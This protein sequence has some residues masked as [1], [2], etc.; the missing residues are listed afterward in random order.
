MIPRRAPVRFSW[1]A[2]RRNQGAL[3]RSSVTN[4]SDNPRNAAPYSLSSNCSLPIWKR[5]RRKP[6]PRRRW[7][8]PRRLWCRRARG[9]G[10]HAARCPDIC[11]ASA[12]SIRRLRSVHAVAAGRC[13]R[14]A[15]TAI[16]LR[17]LPARS[18]RRPRSFSGRG[19]RPL[20]GPPWPRRVPRLWHTEGGCQM[21]EKKTVLPSA[22]CPTEPFTPCQSH[23]LLSLRRA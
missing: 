8:Q 17:L 13:A 21:R 18:S 15:N 16:A 22:R 3:A 2:W 12:S 4:S 20:R 14:S 10:R 9:A 23:G 6:K 7:L 1:T 19:T 5:M 11:R